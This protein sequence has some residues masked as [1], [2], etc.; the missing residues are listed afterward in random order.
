MEAAS[1][2]STLQD[3]SLATARRMNAKP[4]EPRLAAGIQCDGGLGKGTG[5]TLVSV[6]GELA[7]PWQR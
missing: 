4:V 7:I 2:Q 6:D 1:T 5:D 3:A